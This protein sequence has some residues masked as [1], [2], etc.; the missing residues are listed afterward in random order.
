MG[1]AREEGSGTIRKDL[2]WEGWGCRHF[3]TPG[4][5]AQD[6]HSARAQ[7]QPCMSHRSAPWVGEGLVYS[8]SDDMRSHEETAMLLERGGNG[9]SRAEHLV[10]KAVVLI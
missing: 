9:G 7:S 5:P 10:D 6:L 1:L 8:H 3:W 4:L 2:W